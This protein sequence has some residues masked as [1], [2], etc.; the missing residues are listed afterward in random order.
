MGLLSFGIYGYR[1]REWQLALGLLSL[2]FLRMSATR[3]AT[4]IGLA[5][6]ESDPPLKF[7][8]ANGYFDMENY[9]VTVG[10]V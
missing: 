7:A 3:V 4:H 1:C 6:L 9:L 10:A 2:G 5:L 8:A